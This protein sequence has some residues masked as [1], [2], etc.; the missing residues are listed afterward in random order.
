[1][2]IHTHSLT[3]IMWQKVLSH[4]TNKQYDPVFAQ[5]QSEFLDGLNVL[6]K[7]ECKLNGGEEEDYD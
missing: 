4:V 3:N 2:N 5:M 1:M 7:L 6:V